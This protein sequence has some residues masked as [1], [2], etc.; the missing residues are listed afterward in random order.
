[1][2]DDYNLNGSYSDVFRY[3]GKK[4]NNSERVKFEKELEGDAFLKDAVEGL[5]K[6][7]VDDIEN[8]LNSL[9]FIRP[10]KVQFKKAAIVLFII[11][12]LALLFF[13]FIR[14]DENAEE[15]DFINQTTKDSI[16]SNQEPKSTDDSF[17]NDS[18]TLSQ[19]DSIITTRGDSIY[20]VPDTAKDSSIRTTDIEKDTEKVGKIQDDKQ[21]NEIESHEEDKDL[22]QSSAKAEI[23]EVIPHDDTI[24]SK[25][26]TEDAP[27][28]KEVKENLPLITDDTVKDEINDSVS[29][30]TE[31][32]NETVV[33]D[34][35]EKTGSD[36]KAEPVDNPTNKSYSDLE[37]RPGVNAEPK[38]LGGVALFDEYIDNNLRYPLTGNGRQVVK[39]EFTVSLTGELESFQVLRSP[40]DE[41]FQQE[42]IRVLSEG[43]KWSPAIEDGIPVE[44]RE[45]VR[46]VFRP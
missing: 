18:I 27:S 36:Q 28:E 26:V 30:L 2:S 23:N 29:K 37:P 44:S 11:A 22:K 43:P 1:M 35:L 39:I 6:I 42:A 15:D 32:E 34:K 10:R 45:S 20:E 14:N 8:D 9:S 31:N 3:I 46:V 16:T 25:S 33:E 17:I 7:K 5:S 4:M 21:N 19:A 24:K 13:M 12:I 41:A 38:P 40:D